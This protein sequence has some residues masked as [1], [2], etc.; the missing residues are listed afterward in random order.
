[1]IKRTRIKMCGVTNLE[2]ALEGVRAGVDALGFIFVDQSARNVEPKLVREIIGDL[3]PFV[4]CVGVF[5]DREREEVEE[6]V[7][8]CRL[9]YAQL[10]GCEDPKYCERLARFSAPCQ[11]VKAFRVGPDSRAEDFMPYENSVRGYLLDTYTKELA[12]GTGQTFDWQIV[13]QLQ[14]QLPLIL[15]GGLDPE[16]VAEA[17]RVLRPFGVDVNSGIE[18]QPGLKDHE[19]LHAFVEAVRQAHLLSAAQG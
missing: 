5:V 17:I 2:D 3:P 15:A 9:S 14:L 7:E 18:I 4:D 19:K 8:Y 13:E 1:M 10:H 12:G 6:I 16:N 11:V